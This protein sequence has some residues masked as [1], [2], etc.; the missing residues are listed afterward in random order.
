[1]ETYF[2]MKMFTEF[3]LPFV[4][5]L[6]APL[7]A[8]ICVLTLTIKEYIKEYRIK[9]FF[10]SNGYKRENVGVSS[11][12]LGVFYGWV[13]ESDGKRAND[14]DIEEMSL[15]QIKEKYE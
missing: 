3:I 2:K 10:L 12:G 8:V 6:I 15:Q 11:Y 4:C 7:V 5:I 1:M 13:R 14:I 9:K